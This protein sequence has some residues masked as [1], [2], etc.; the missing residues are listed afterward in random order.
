MKPSHPNTVHRLVTAV[1]TCLLAIPLAAQETTQTAEAD[2]APVAAPQVVSPEAQAVLARMTAYMQGLQ[3]F[4][5]D[6]RSTRDEVLPYGYKLQ[7]NERASLVVQRPNRLRSEVTGDLRHRTF[8]YDGSKLVIYSPDHQAYARVAAP[9]TI[10]KLITG[11]LDAGVE[12]PLIDVLYQSAAG[13][14]TEQVRNGILVGDSTVEGVEC[15]HLAFRQADTD[16]QL[17]VAKGTQPLPRKIVIT[18][19]YEIGNPQFEAILNRNL[20]PKLSAST[21]TFVAPKGAVEIPFDQPT[22]I[23]GDAQ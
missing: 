6:S 10:A 16:W 19:R 1:V 9:D 12:L 22:A 21:F 4:S 14:L 20:K 3:N 17:W 2:A 18:T 15:D 11:I 5:I 23:A 7:N 13:T 8:V